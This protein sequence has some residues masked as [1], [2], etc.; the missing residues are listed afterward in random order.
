MCKSSVIAFRNM[1]LFEILEWLFFLVCVKE[2][3]WPPVVF[4][5]PRLLVP[6]DE[7]IEALKVAKAAEGEV[8]QGLSKVWAF[9][10]SIGMAWLY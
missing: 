6:A 8:A 10:F 9:P 3:H 2:T 7:M 5:G 4:G 1:S